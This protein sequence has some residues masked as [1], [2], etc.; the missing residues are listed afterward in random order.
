MGKKNIFNNSNS[1]VE[2]PTICTSQM[3]RVF[4]YIKDKKIDDSEIETITID[5]LHSPIIP[6][7]LMKWYKIN[8]TFDNLIIDTGFIGFIDSTDPVYTYTVGLRHK[9][10]ADDNCCGNNPVTKCID[11]TCSGLSKNCIE[12][13]TTDKNSISISYDIPENVLDVAIMTL[14]VIEKIGTMDFV[15]LGAEI[16]L[17][18]Y[19]YK[20]NHE[21]LAIIPAL[22]GLSNVS[23][24]VN[25]AGKF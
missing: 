10:N 5:L 2:P 23:R 6:Q 25:N 8:I 22:Y 21:I 14:P 16:Y 20:R 3:Q 12:I 17:T 24:I 9:P 19:L 1:L 7:G 13:V 4:D 18:N 11:D 15:W